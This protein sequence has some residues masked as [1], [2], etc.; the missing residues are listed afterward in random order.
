MAVPAGDGEADSK[1]RYCYRL[2]APILAECVIPAKCKLR[3]KPKQVVVSLRKLNDSQP[4]QELHKVKGIGE[5]GSIQP[6]YG[7]TTTLSS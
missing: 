7:E 6:D 1:L 5:T 3:V 4:W 2:H